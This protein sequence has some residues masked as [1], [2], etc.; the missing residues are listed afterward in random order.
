ML[1]AF[2][3]S[4]RADGMY[5]ITELGSLPG[6]TS[7]AATGINSLGQVVGESGVF[8]TSYAAFLYSNGTMAALN[9]DIPSAISDTGKLAID[10]AGLK[11]YGINA[12]GVEAGYV[13][14]GVAA[15]AFNGVATPIPGLY[16]FSQA[17]AINDAGEVVGIMTT[18]YNKDYH[19]FIYQDGKLT[20]I[21]AIAAGRR[22][23]GGKR[24]Q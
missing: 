15:T 9:T 10:Q 20:D 7:T 23:G 14:P 5:T 17:N 13:G 16:G 6:A 2:A 12:S 21:G 3:A 18:G 24:D 11:A 4:A 1:S 22:S 19:P 8:G